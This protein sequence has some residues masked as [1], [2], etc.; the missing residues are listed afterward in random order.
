MNCAETHKLRGE[1]GY[2]AQGDGSEVYLQVSSVIPAQLATIIWR[3]YCRIVL[4]LFIYSIHRGPTYRLNGR[5]TALLS[6]WYDTLGTKVTPD[7]S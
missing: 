2:A 4:L 6:S 5:Y 7:A 1:F 3:R